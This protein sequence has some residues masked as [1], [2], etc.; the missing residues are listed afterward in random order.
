MNY[1]SPLSNSYLSPPSS[2]S[3]S[4]SSAYFDCSEYLS[5]DK[6]S[7]YGSI[8]TTILE[9]EDF[10]NISNNTI[11]PIVDLSPAADLITNIP[12]IITPSHSTRTRKLN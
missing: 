4:G 5:M 10:D 12:T 11:T 8:R 2:S 3:Q 7:I 6:S 1:L 9:D